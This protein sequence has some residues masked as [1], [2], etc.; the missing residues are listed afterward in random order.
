MSPGDQE[1]YTREQAAE[2]TRDAVSG[3][4]ALFAAE[5]ATW[6]LSFVM[7]VMMPRYL[8]ATGF[9]RLY[10]ALSITAIMSIL[11]EFGLNS[12]VAREVARQREHATRYLFNAAILKAGLWV[13]AFVVVGAF[14]RVVD[15]PLETQVAIAILAIGV[16]FAAESS[17]VVAILQAHERMR[18]I[19]LSTVVAKFVY[20]GLGVSALLMGYGVVALATVTTLGALAG[21]LLDLWWFRRVAREGDVHAGWRGFELPTLFVRALPF[22]SV[23]FF[24]AVY[25]RVDVVILS[26]LA[27][28]AA[29]GYYGAAYRLFQATYI[30]PNAFLFA[31][32]PMFCR[33]SEQAG[34]ALAAAA[35]KSLD[36]LLLVG[37]PIAIGIAAL[38]DEI[39]GVL[40]GAG[41]SASIPMLR[42]LSLGVALMYANGVF[43]QLLIATE[44]QRRLA[45]T[46]GIASV[47]NVGINVALIPVLGG[48]GAAIATVATEA[49]VICLNF[50]FLPRSLTRELHFGMPG[51]ALIAASAMGGL[52][53]LLSGRSLLLLVPLGIASYVAAVVALK[54]VSPDDWTMMKSAVVNLRRASWSRAR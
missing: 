44:R 52:L 22:F 5:A 19:A 32:F 17:L 47:L 39:V 21:L 34:D 23:A 11:V 13:I 4:L 1:T 30:L 42:V 9:G 20:V 12:L 48:L 50:A 16:L 6:G 43:V 37:L 54:A 14:A 8:G 27:S 2:E 18:W 36:L 24:G 53:M 45:L 3:G 40:Y 28:D 7:T 33:L 41:F 29:V 31:L 51:R 26:L 46:A 15:Y 49:A 35:Q 25:F 38:S 10:L